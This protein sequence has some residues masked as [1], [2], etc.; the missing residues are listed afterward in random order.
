MYEPKH[1]KKW[2]RVS[3][4][5]GED[6]SDWYI[7]VVQTRDSY[8]LERTNFSDVKDHLKEQGFEITGNL[9]DCITDKAILLA[10]FGHWACGWIESL[11]IHKDNDK[12]L[13]AGDEIR[14]QLDDYPIFDEESYS[15]AELGMQWDYVREYI[16]KDHLRDNDID[17]DDSLLDKI[18]SEL[19][20]TVDFETNGYDEVIT[21]DD[22]DLDKIIERVNHLTLCQVCGDEID[23]RSESCSC[24]MSLPI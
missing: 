1:M 17:Y 20:K 7:L 12:A 22:Y 3:D 24:Q 6:L 5:G 15:V 23:G 8:L 14:S 9:E 4:Y 18:T 2:Q 10:S 21:S 13:Q 19:F 16:V 11:M